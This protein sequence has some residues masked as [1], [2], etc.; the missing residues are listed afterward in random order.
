MEDKQYKG[1]KILVVGPP[2]SGKST[3]AHLISEMLE[4]YGLTT[5]MVDDIDGVPMTLRARGDLHSTWGEPSRSD[6]IYD[7]LKNK[8]MTIEQYQVSRGPKD[9]KNNYDY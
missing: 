5:E 2:R 9:K 8:K 7:A 1:L 6:I 3:V 4:E